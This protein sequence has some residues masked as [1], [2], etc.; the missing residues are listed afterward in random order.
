MTIFGVVLWKVI[1]IYGFGIITGAAFL[2]AL[3][4]C[5]AAGGGNNERRRRERPGR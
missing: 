2:L 4:L 5:D 3:A 1:A